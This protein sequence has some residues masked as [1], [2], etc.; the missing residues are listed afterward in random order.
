MTPFI[1]LKKNVDY[2]IYAIFVTLGMVYTGFKNQ[3]FE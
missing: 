3:K 1:M 2:F